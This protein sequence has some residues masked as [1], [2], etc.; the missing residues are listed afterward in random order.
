MDRNFELKVSKTDWLK[1]VPNTL[2]KVWA[3]GRVAPARGWP[4]IIIDKYLHSS[5]PYCLFATKSASFSKL[6]SQ[7]LSVNSSGAAR[8][9]RQSKYFTANIAYQAES[10]SV[11]LHLELAD[12]ADENLVNS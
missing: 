4:A 5:N 3:N 9:H 1:V 7:K 8:G 10:C 12:P 11:K 2:T 6:T